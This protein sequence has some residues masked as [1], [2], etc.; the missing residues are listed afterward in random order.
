[1][2][3]VDVAAFTRSS[4]CLMYLDKCS[5]P[6][7]LCT[8]TSWC[9]PC[10]CWETVWAQWDQWVQWGRFYHVLAWKCSTQVLLVSYQC[11]FH[12]A[13]WMNTRMHFQSEGENPDLPLALKFSSS[14]SHCQSYPASIAWLKMPILNYVLFKLQLNRK[15]NTTIIIV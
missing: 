11:S 3:A 2:H 13:S 8:Q 7:L 5:S 14:F 15:L 9:C 10:W 6:A 12:H 1:M 4:A